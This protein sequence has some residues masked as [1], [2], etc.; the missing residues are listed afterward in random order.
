MKKSRS[1]N[2]NELAAKLKGVVEFSLLNIDMNISLDF[3]TAGEN[4]QHVNNWLR[5]VK[6]L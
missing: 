1:K 5:L 2:L 4:I 6:C 3:Q